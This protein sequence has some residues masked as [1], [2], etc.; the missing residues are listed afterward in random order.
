MEESLLK[1]NFVGRDGFRW[2]IGQVAL[3]DVWAEQKD[4]KGWGNRA[5]VRIMGYHPANTVELKDEDLPWAQIVLPMTA[6]TGGQ[7]SAQK[8]RV[9]PGDIVFGFFMDGDNAQVPVIVG[10]FGNTSYKPEKAYSGPFIPFT[11][12]TNDIKPPDGKTSQIVG[13]NTNEQSSTSQPSAVALQK[14][15]VQSAGGAGA[16]GISDAVGDKKLNATKKPST[17]DK[18]ENSLNNFLKDYAEFEDK[19]GK[20]IED[21][22]EWLKQEIDFRV[23]QLEEI[24]SQQVGGAVTAVL[25]KL[26]PLVKAALKILYSTV[27]GLVFAATLNPTTANKAGELAE[28][29]MIPVVN[30]IEKRI[31]CLIESIIKSIG[32]IIRQMLYAIV[33]NIANFVSCVAEQFMGSIMNS[34]I[35]QIATG[36]Q[37]AIGGLQSILKYVDGFDTEDFLRSTGEAFLGML[38][39][40][41]CEEDED[42]SDTK[43]WIVGYGTKMPRVSDINSIL[44]LA[45]T[46]FSIADAQSGAGNPIEGVSQI[47]GAFDIFNE[48]IKQPDFSGISDCFAGIPQF[49]GPPTINIFGGGGSGASGIPLFGNIVEAANGGLTGGIIGIKMTNPGSGYVYP[50]FVEVTDSCN[51]GYGAV[52]RATVKDGQVNS[53]YIVSEGENYPAEEQP[54][55]VSEV[56]VIDTGSGYSP[57]DTVVDQLGNKYETQIASGYIVKVTPINSVNVTSLP[58]LS[59]VTETGVGAILK[60]KLDIIPDFQGE[61]QRVVDCVTT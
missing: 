41:K 60:P 10:A 15:Q 33:D 40:P 43:E 38:G 4:G 12:F 19:I 16:V 24:V 52:A 45:N 17:L 42:D 20:G 32:N 23:K 55:I 25:N 50:P 46:A 57:G 2:W 35:G 5:K 44:E 27:Y 61:V 49:C 6:G 11:G 53:I 47:V 1:S 26:I 56:S 14:S 7:G 48:G 54:Y 9:A 28:K 18:I 8:V 13:G 31:P 58:I 29:A 30:E 34:I 51:Q 3:K 21:A 39:L 22:R 37:S 36:L 59:V